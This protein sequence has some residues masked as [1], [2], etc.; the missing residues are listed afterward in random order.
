MQLLNSLHEKDRAIKKA[1]PNSWAELWDAGR[2][3][4]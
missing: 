1:H 2:I 4:V 3:K